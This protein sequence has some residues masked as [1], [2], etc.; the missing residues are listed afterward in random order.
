MSMQNESGSMVF[1]GDGFTVTS[2]TEDGVGKMTFNE[3]GLV[4]RHGDNTVT[5][6]P[7]S[8]EVMNITN[9]DDKVFEVNEDGELS[10][11]G[12][13]IARSLRLEN[14]VTI[15]SGVITNLATVATSGSYNDLVDTPNLT[16]FITKDVSNLT[17]YYN[18]TETENLLSGKANAN[19]LSTVATSGS[20]NDLT[21][22]EDF[23]NWVLQ[24]IQSAI[25]Q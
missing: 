16:A 14:G 23:K 5:I 6:S 7:K 15:D 22:I 3:N 20:Y 18:K 24:Q 17:N 9:G 2:D 19:D 11:N 25:G 8:E 4:V 13:I 21:D 12:N 10:I 1:N